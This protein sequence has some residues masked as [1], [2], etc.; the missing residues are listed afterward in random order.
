MALVILK[1]K[2]GDLNDTIF[3]VIFVICYLINPGAG[4]IKIKNKEQLTTPM[5]LRNNQE[6]K[7][8]KTRLHIR[9]KKTF[10]EKII[11][12]MLTSRQIIHFL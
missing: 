8:S 12:K 6:K 1:A 2:R 5:R 3:H 11:Q 4:K 7:Y 9:L 10:Q